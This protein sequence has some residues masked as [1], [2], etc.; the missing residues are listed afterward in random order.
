MKAPEV[1]AKLDSLS[2]IIEI[3]WK[4]KKGHLVRRLY[5]R[6]GTEVVRIL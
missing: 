6:K 1:V 3:D 2:L 4:G 5:K